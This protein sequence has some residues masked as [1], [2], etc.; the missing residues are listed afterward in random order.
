M[1]SAAG[2]EI[3]LAIVGGGPAGMSLALFLVALDPSWS[4]RLVVLE[5]A[6]FPRD[7][8][9]AGAIAGR[10]LDRLAAIDALPD[11]P[12]VEV[13]GLAAETPRGGSEVRGPERVGWVVR[14]LAFDAALAA[15]A[16][17]RGVRVQEGARVLGL[18]RTTA[19]VSIAL[20]EQPPLP[21]RAVVGADGV[22]SVVRRALGFGRGALF[23]RA[24]EIDTETRA[25]DGSDD[26]LR[27][28]LLPAGIAGYAWDFPTPLDGG[29]ARSR[30]VYVLPR[31]GAAEADPAALLGERLAA[32]GGPRVLGPVRRFSERGFTPAAPA[33]VARALLVGEAR[34]VDPVLGEGIAQAIEQA[35]FAARYLH[36]AFRRDD[37]RFDDF[38]ARAQRTRVGL[39]LELRARAAPWVYGA[40]RSALE[41]A[42]CHPSLG[43]I[44]LAYFAG[45]P[46]ARRD[47]ARAAGALVT[48]A[49]RS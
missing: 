2:R 26:V 44:G 4:E 38:D 42:L 45:R 30:G 22:G 25:V 41:R 20:A 12:H 29:V 48:S 27:F 10:A 17:R 32:R 35:A 33:A 1:R 15:L 36:D 28:A 37:L 14:R 31:V 47:W 18:V 16:A 19:G 9:C 13:R 7:K 39:D 21:V 46:T 11:V 24:A 23:A 8:I 43:R 49:T 6:H 5:R 34:G 40:A 3:D